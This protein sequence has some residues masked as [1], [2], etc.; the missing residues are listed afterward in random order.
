M[1]RLQREGEALLELPHLGHLAEGMW[2]H[3]LFKY[4]RKIAA[5][6]DTF[7]RLLWKT[8]LTIN[9]DVI[10]PHRYRTIEEVT[11]V[12]KRHVRRHLVTL[13]GAIEQFEAQYEG[14][15]NAQKHRPPRKPQEG[16]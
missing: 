5:D 12:Q 16:R 4:L 6:P 11:T 2:A 7:E 1:L 13:A 15:T 9:L 8:A 3:R 10:E 14:Q